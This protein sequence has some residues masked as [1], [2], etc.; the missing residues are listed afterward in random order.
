MPRISMTCFAASRSRSTAL[1]I[2]FGISP[3]WSNAWVLRPSTKVEK[4]TGSVRIPSSWAGG[5]SD[6]SPAGGDS[7]AVSGGVSPRASPVS[8]KRRRSVTRNPR[9]SSFSLSMIIPAEGATPPSAGSPRSSLSRPA[10]STA[11][12][13]QPPDALLDRRMGA[14][15]VGEPV[16]T[17]RAHDPEVSRRRT[18]RE[19]DTAGDGGDLLE[20]RGQLLGPVQDACPGSVSLVF[21]RARDRELNQRGRD[22]GDDDHREEAERAATL[23]ALVAPHPAE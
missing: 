17:Q 11:H 22:R 8:A 1:V 14:E 19:R 5:I 23:L 21:A 20:G 6:R 7:A 4:L 10:R 18:S 9:R 2:G 12:R 16:A 3:R 13:A 15:Q